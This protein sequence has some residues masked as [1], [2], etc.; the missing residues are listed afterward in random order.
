[1]DGKDV[2][3]VLQE[4]FE[5]HVINHGDYSLVYAQPCAPGPAL[6]IGYRRTPLELVLCPVEL[7]HLPHASGDGSRV[8]ARLAAPVS[9][10][11]LSN[12]A[13]LADTGTGYQVQSVTGFRTWFEVEGAARISVAASPVEPG[14]SS[15]VVEQDQEAEDFH[16]FMAHFMDVLDGFY[17]VP[18]VPEIAQGAFTPSLAA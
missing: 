17:R 8:A 2:T 6:V 13:T 5:A 16:Q 18:D 11:D 9:S 1:M 7:A 15:V 10:I 4:F 3:R 12:V 14:N